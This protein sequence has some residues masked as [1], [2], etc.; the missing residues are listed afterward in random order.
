[1]L[2]RPAGHRDIGQFADVVLEADAVLGPQTFDD[3][4]TLLE[5]ADALAARHA[6]GVELDIA[7]AEP[8]AEDE[9]APPDRVERGDVLSDF[10]RIVQGRAIIR[11]S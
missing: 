1:L 5:A 10:D 3:F 9:I 8:D 4:E 2:D 6:K 7:I 11:A